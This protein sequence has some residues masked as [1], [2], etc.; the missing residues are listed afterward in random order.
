MD[1]IKIWHGWIIAGPGKCIICW[2][3]VCT[4]WDTHVPSTDTCSEQ[5]KLSFLWKMVAVL[6]HLTSV[7]ITVLYAIGNDTT[8]Y[9][10]LTIYGFA[11]MWVSQ[12]HSLMKSFW[13]RKSHVN[14]S[15]SR[16]LP[17]YLSACSA[18]LA[19]YTL[20]SLSVMLLMVSGLF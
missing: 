12:A 15:N 18:S 10:S 13:G 3:D 4:Y 5:R 8:L 20:S 16:Y 17:S 11:H 9:H 1:G 19:L 2:W 7:L 14:A 6:V